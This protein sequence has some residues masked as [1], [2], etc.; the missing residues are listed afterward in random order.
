VQKHR[1]KLTPA[2]HLL[3][4]D[5]SFDVR[6]FLPTTDISTRAS[7]RLLYRRR[8]HSLLISLRSEDKERY[9]GI[10]SSSCGSISAL[11]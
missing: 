4:P 8:L 6:G 3:G 11:R 5:R 10:T 1:K 9:G 2:A 7:S